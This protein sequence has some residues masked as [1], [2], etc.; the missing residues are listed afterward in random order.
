MLSVIESLG[1]ELVNAENPRR[2]RAVTCIARV[3]EALLP[4]GVLTDKE[5]ELLT[6][7][8]CSKLGDHHSILPPTLCGLVALVSKC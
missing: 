2:C 6:A 4:Q 8:F 1:P 5:I 3:V 7:F